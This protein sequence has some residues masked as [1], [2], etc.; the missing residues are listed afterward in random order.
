MEIE[1]STT[2]LKKK[3]K[4]TKRVLLLLAFVFGV[5]LLIYLLLTAPGW[6]DRY[7]PAFYFYTSWIAIFFG[8]TGVMCTHICVKFFALLNNA[9]MKKIRKNSKQR[10]TR[11]SKIF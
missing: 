8:V 6:V 11:V 1:K 7:G 10:V 2:K 3:K 9:Q 4:Q 5:P